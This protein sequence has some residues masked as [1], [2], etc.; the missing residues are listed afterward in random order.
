MTREFKQWSN[1]QCRSIYTIR[2]TV[3]TVYKEE[4]EE[5]EGEDATYMYTFLLF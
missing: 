3:R 1:Q 4:V 2:H 5:E